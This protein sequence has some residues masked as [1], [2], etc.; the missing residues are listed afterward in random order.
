MRATGARMVGRGT[1]RW[2]GDDQGRCAVGGAVWYQPDREVRPGTN[3][4]TR[5]VIVPGGQGGG[6]RQEESREHKNSWRDGEE[7]KHNLQGS[8]T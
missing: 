6:K 3:L 8:R 4:N 2:S 7:V 5:I 1:C